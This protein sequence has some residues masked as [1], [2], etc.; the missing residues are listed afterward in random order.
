MVEKVN[1]EF[2]EWM[3]EHLASAGLSVAPPPPPVFEASAPAAA[4]A[5][6]EPKNKPDPW[7]EQDPWGGKSS[8]TFV[9][10]SGIRT[11]IPHEKSQSVPTANTGSNP[12]MMSQEQMMQQMMQMQQMLIRMSLE[13]SRPNTMSDP[14]SSYA[15][16]N[17]S[18]SVLGPTVLP[19]V[20]Q[21][22]LRKLIGPEPAEPWNNW[23]NWNQWPS[24]RGDKVPVPKWDGSQPGRRLKPWLKELRIWRRETEVPVMKQGLALYRSFEAGNW[25][26]QAAERVP[27][28]QLYTSE[29]WELILKEILTT[30]KPYLD[31]ELDVLIEETVFQT[32]KESKESMTAYVTKKLNKKRELL[33]ALGQTQS[34]CNGCGCLNSVPKDFPEEVWSYLLRRGA[35]L[36]E[37]QRKQIHQWDSG[38]LTG[39]RLM[40]LLLRLEIGR[41][42]V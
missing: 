13:R 35:H 8:D 40:E 17:Q 38:V 37:D 41:A 11:D 21:P 16:G 19:T 29:A 27:E 26:K 15:P 5:V 23:Q 4:A 2:D 34:K 28:E 14:T 1:E 32:Q 42:H 36:T 30:L 12:P 18:G 25:M 22:Q 3:E 20:P 9:S 7:V 39:N 10:G 31:V 24:G 33:A 6:N